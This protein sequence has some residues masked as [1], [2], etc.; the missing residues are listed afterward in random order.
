MTHLLL[1]GL[2]KMLLAPGAQF[3]EPKQ[4]QWIDLGKGIV[5][6]LYGEADQPKEKPRDAAQE[7]Q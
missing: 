3:P 2:W 6:M 7:E 5:V 4:A 1:T